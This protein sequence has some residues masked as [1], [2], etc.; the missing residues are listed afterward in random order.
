MKLNDKQVA[1]PSADR[2]A[3]LASQIEACN[4]QYLWYPYLPIGDYTVMM[5]AGGTGKTVL[6][7]GIAAAV[8]IGGGPPG[9]ALNGEGKDVL[10]ISAEDSGSVLR[11]RLEQS[12]ADLDRIHILDRG[13]SYGMDF[14]TYIGEFVGVIR[15]VSPA[16]IIIDP[17]HAFLGPSVDMNR[18]N[19]LRP[20]LQLLA[21]VAKDWQCSMIL[22]SHVNKGRQAENI[23]NAALGSSDFIN[24]AR[25]AV[26]V[27]FG[28]TEKDVRIMV[29]TKSN[30]APYGE[31]VQYRIVD[32]GG[33]VWEGY[34]P[35][36][37]WDLEE[38]AR[39][40]CTPGE[41]IA[42][43]DAKVTLI[44]ALKSAIVKDGP[45]RY[46]YEEFIT[47]Y[48]DFVFGGRQPK[49][50]LDAVASTL[51]A[52]GIHLETGIHVKRGNSVQNGFLVQRINL[53]D[54]QS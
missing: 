42:Q 7:C 26:R 39:Q 9:M 47:L 32:G 43:K 37:R 18:P 28:G 54:T 34:S 6:C 24:A 10:I 49:R 33:I 22:I 14:S 2:I 19:V 40:R 17:W 44:V 25:S 3:V 41:L 11:K 15:D 4:T 36:T 51:L 46:T 38:A 27:I 23:N 21:Q 16:L 8:S 53:V 31:S 1:Q 52:E 29:H 35:I 45:N 20:V 50:A 30:Y 48:G 13:L 5:A 12:G